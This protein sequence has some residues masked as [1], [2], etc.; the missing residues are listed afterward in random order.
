[1]HKAKQ[2]R[3]DLKTLATQV[4]ATYAGKKRP[5]DT[6]KRSVWWTL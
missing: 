1:M 6:E 5:C 4:N 2:G 3:E